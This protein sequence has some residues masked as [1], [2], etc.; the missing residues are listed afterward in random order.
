MR[1][2]E[3]RRGAR[4]TGDADLEGV[5]S[6]KDRVVVGRWYQAASR[7]QYLS[8]DGEW[9][10]APRDRRPCRASYRDCVGT[11]EVRQSA[12]RELRTFGQV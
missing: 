7:Q 11:R 6:R 8:R 1:S 12:W 2:H 3:R 10:V 5:E 4:V 9:G